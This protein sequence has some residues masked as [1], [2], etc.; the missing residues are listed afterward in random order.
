MCNLLLVFTIVGE[1]ICLEG[2]DTLSRMIHSLENQSSHTFLT[3]VHLKTSKTG[4]RVETLVNKGYMLLFV[5]S[6][7]D[8]LTN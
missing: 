4:I 8:G 1:K 5:T 2:T 7:R 3:F 6:K